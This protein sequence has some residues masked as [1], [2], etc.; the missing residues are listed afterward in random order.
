MESLIDNK[1]IIIAFYQKGVKAT[2]EVCVSEVSEVSEVSDGL[3]LLV[4]IFEIVWPVDAEGVSIS[5][6]ANST[7]ALTSALTSLIL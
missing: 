7:A 3:Y 1:T 2:G 4:L 6:I 5:A